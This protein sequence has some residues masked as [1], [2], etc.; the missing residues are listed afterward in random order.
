MTPADP[1]FA[2]KA[3]RAPATGAAPEGYVADA[4]GIPRMGT[5][6][7]D[8]TSH[9]FHGQAFTNTMVLGFYDARLVFFEPMMTKAFLESHPDATKTIAL[10]AQVPAPGAYPTTYRVRYDNAAAEYRVELLDFV[11]RN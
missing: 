1:Q 8:R 2:Q 6:W 7:T 4:F 5:H 9:E 11:N 10:P 3:T